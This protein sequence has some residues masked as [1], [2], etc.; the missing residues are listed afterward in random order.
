[1]QLT[2]KIKAYLAITIV[3]LTTNYTIPTNYAIINMFTMKHEQ[4]AYMYI[5]IWKSFE[6]VSVLTAH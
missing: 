2:N 1:M 3:V 4:H 5:Y 6:E